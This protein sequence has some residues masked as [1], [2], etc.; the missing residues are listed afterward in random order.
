VYW[1]QPVKV[2]IMDV[3]GNTNK[4]RGCF[5]RFTFGAAD[6]KFGGVRVKLPHGLI[7]EGSNY[8]PYIVT[9]VAYSWKEK[10]NVV[11]CFNDINHTYAF[12]FDPKGSYIAV[13][14]TGFFVEKEG[15]AISSLVKTMNGG[16]ID[17]RLSATLK[18][19]S[20]TFGQDVLTG[21]LVGIDSDTTNQ[22]YNLQSYTFHFLP[23]RVSVNGDTGG[24]S[25]DSGSESK[26]PQ[27]PAE[28]HAK[29]LADMQRKFNAG[30]NFGSGGRLG[31]RAPGSSFSNNSS[32]R[33]RR[34]GSK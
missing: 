17:G 18:P 13:G 26:G 27:T 29:N 7:L 16:Y 25:G 8:D 19:G 10:F 4:A 15:T 33:V 34:L 2:I 32:R 11:E 14:L 9:R 21:F 24:G 1:K 31:N 12:G 30:N 3:F 5:H 28:R 23:V 20:I 6:G 22:E